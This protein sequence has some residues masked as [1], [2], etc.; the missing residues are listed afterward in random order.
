VTGA[1]RGIGRAIALELA[2]LGAAVVVNFRQ[3]EDEA[4]AVA[5][6]IVADGGRA[7]VVQA[8]VSDKA[9]CRTLV[10]KAVQRFGGLDVLVSNA[11]ITQDV[12]FRKMDDDA[13]RRVLDV[14]LN[15][16]YNVTS[17]ALEHMIRRNF[18]RVVMVSSVIAQSGGFG[19]TNYA[20]SKAALIG[21]T[22]SLA[23]EVARHNV[24]VNAVCPGF[25][26]TD[27]VARVPADV[28][29]K[30][31]QKIPARRLGKA[32]EVAGAVA[33]L[34]SRG[35]YVTGQQINVNGGLYV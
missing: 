9:Q 17:L 28:L 3:R 27:M 35:D 26:D 24:T 14:N 33:F 12:T 18:G 21:F 34:V 6:K 31:V 20:A 7:L 16:A 2:S 32:E 4:T 1:S 25:C 22:K 19:Q 30:V 10:D 11:G 5:Q 29:D 23:L 13:W 8:D 15:G